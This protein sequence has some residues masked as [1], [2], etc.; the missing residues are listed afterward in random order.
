MSQLK[1]LLDDLGKTPK[2]IAKKLLSLDCKGYKSNAYF[3]PI[4]QYLKSNGYRSI[5]VD[6][7]SIYGDTELVEAS[8]SISNFIEQ[9]DEGKYPSLIY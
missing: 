6:I 2:Q 8:K 3:C 5:E 1:K 7:H 4:A 9:F